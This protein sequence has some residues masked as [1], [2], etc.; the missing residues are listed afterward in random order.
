M[1]ARLPLIIKKL[2]QY[3]GRPQW[4]PRFSPVEELVFTILSQNTSDTNASRALVSLKRKFCRWEDV[5][6]APASSIAAAIHSSGLAATKAR[7][8]KDTLTGILEEKG[9]LSLGFLKE[10]NDQEALRYLTKYTGVGVKTASCVLLFSLGR[11][12]MP[13][14]THVFRVSKRLGLLGKNVTRNAAHKILGA[15][16]PP[17]DI[18]SFHVNLV[19]HGRR[20]CRAQM[21]LCDTCVIEPLCPA[22]TA[23][24]SPVSSPVPKSKRCTTK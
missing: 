24:H 6:R 5:V 14:D 12:L 11:P 10:M 1:P 23:A 20:I 17:S 2:E 3:Y 4:K 21:P 7:Y 13:V 8:I 19:R 22:S 18:F 15:V 9:D 16:T